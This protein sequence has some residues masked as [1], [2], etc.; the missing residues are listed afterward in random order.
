MPMCGS[1][2]F[3]LLERY[4][5]GSD[6]GNYATD[7][8]DNAANDHHLLAAGFLMVGCLVQLIHSLRHIAH[9]LLHVMLNLIQQFTLALHQNSHVNEQLQRSVSASYARDWHT[10]SPDAAR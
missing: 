8:D 6:G 9:S 1:L 7:D 4:D 10:R 3:F 2:F 5:A